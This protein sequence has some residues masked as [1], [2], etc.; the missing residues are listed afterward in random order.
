MWQVVFSSVL[1]RL[2]YLWVHL[3]V[4]LKLLISLIANKFH[5]PQKW[6]ERG[7]ELRATCVCTQD[8]DRKVYNWSFTDVWICVWMCFVLTWF[9]SCNWWCCWCWWWIVPSGI[10]RCNKLRCLHVIGDVVATQWCYCCVHCCHFGYSR[11]WMC[12]DCCIRY[13]YCHCRRRRR[14]CWLLYCDSCYCLRRCRRRRWCMCD[15]RH[16]NSV[17]FFVH[18]TI[19]YRRYN[20]TIII[21]VYSR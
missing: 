19:I 16:L 7:R 12:A 3:F 1:V 8:G 14:C 15:C 13:C 21:I 5:S 20:A 4:G 9:I 18:C 11:R 10:R 2:K 6:D 17:I